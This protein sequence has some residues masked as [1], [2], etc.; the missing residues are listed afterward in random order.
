M[1]FLSKSKTEFIQVHFIDTAAKGLIP[2]FAR[3]QQLHSAAELHYLADT[4]NWDDGVSVLDWII[5]SPRC[6]YGTALLI[7]WRAQPDF[8]TQFESEQE[9]ADE[10]DIFRLLRTVIRNWETGFYQHHRIGYDPVAEELLDFERPD[11]K[12][13]IPIAFRLGNPGQAVVAQQALEKWL[14]GLLHRLWHW[15]RQR[16][17]ALNRRRH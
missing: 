17:R 4:Y 13:A 6:D 11:A 10:E 12:W 7:F 14:A 5:S 2:D 9:A 15:R 1:Y 8:Y 16:R 3:F